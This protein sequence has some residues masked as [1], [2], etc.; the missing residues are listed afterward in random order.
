LVKKIGI[1]LFLMTGVWLL[2]QNRTI[3]LTG[4]DGKPVLGPDGKPATVT[5][6]VDGPPPASATAPAVPPDRVV[7]TVG[8]EK[9]TAGELNSIVEILPEQLRAT[10]RGAG[11]RQFAENIVRLKLLAQE[12]RRRKMDQTPAFQYQSAFQVEN[13]LAALL[14]QDINNNA[15]VDEPAAREYYDQHK[16][17]YERVHAR[18]ILV[19]MAGSAIPVKPGQKDLSADEALAKAQELRKKLAAGADFA[20]LAGAESDDS[21]TGSRGGD[22]GFFGH[23]QMVPS[24]EQAAFAMKAGDISDPVRSQFGYHIIK[25][26]AREAKAFEEARPSIEQKLKPQMTQKFLDEMRKSAT[27][28]LDPSYFGEEKKPTPPAPP[29]A[30]APKP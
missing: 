4:P 22:L 9:V 30:P 27:V 19:R 15:K 12:A 18:H 2:A 3:P 10:A 29:A 6:S 16:A 11:R 8:S 20:A 23:G 14:A 5:L 17:E 28:T 26:E 25:V 21:T 24:F 1:S 7:L 13:L